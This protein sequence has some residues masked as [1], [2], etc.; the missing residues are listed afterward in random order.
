M[1]THTHRDCHAHTRIAYQ[2]HL[3]QHPCPAGTLSVLCFWPPSCLYSYILL[4]IHLFHFN[5]STYENLQLEPR[6]PSPSPL[7]LLL[8]LLQG[9]HANCVGQ[10]S[11]LVALAPPYPHTPRCSTPLQ[12]ANLLRLKA[13]SGCHMAKFNAV[14]KG[15]RG[16]R[17][18]GVKGSAGG[19]RAGCR[20]M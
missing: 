2:Q 8:C 16:R 13:I 1:P 14:S 9:M 19:C 4:Y 11:F 12:T 18:M 3:P 20:G 6:P 15:G 7:V 5:L 10:L 17:C